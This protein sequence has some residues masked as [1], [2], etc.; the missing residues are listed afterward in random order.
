MTRLD[1]LYGMVK[2]DWTKQEIL[3]EIDSIIED[4]KEYDLKVK[5][6]EN[7]Y[8]S[9]LSWFGRGKPNTTYKVYV[10]EIEL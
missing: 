9:G 7:G 2:Q 8:L 4:T 1:N 6:D 5:S 3:D 10:E